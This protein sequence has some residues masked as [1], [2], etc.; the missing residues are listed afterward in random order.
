MMESPRA[1]GREKRKVNKLTQQR[2]GLASATEAG[3]PCL[4]MEISQGRACSACS[5]PFHTSQQDWPF[6]CLFP[7]GLSQ[8]AAAQIIRRTMRRLDRDLG[9]EVL[10]GRE[11]FVLGAARHITGKGSSCKIYLTVLPHPLVRGARLDRGPPSHQRSISL[12]DERVGGERGRGER[13]R[14]R[15]SRKERALKH[16][17]RL[18]Q[19]TPKCAWVAEWLVSIRY[20][21]VW[22]D[23]NGR[24]GGRE[25]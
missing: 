3:H 24:V 7:R 22:M 18:T 6:S 12:C 11:R 2:P 1:A 10:P 21:H 17:A 16:R 23:F 9:V 19:R 5:A 8:R 13:E 15:E 25:S 4:L 14:Q 20:I